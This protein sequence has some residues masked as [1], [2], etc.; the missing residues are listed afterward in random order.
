MESEKDKRNAYAV[1]EATIIFPIIIMI[2]AGIVLLSMYLPTR[3]LLQRATQYA[4]TAIATETSDTWLF[5]DFNGMHYS[6]A[7]SRSDLSN[8]YVSLISSFKST[9]RDDADDA[10]RIVSAVVKSGVSTA[11]G[12][13]QV[14][15]TVVNHIVYKEIIV[16][17]T[18]RI[19]SPVRMP[20]VGF[21]EEIPITVSSTAVVTNGDEFVRNIDIA[22]DLAGFLAEKTGLDDLFG[23]VGEFFD[24]VY[25]FLGI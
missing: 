19:P 23:K 3:A 24:K 15:Y 20:M 17:A 4:A 22:A 8:V 12:K 6:W 9:N 7:E 13:L 21:P 5:Y 2:F 10:E 18:K 14:E 16:T 11:P 1:V 25:N